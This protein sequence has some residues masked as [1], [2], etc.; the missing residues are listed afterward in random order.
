MLAIATMIERLQLCEWAGLLI[1]NQVVYT[2]KITGVATVYMG[3]V[4]GIC[5][6]LSSIIQMFVTDNHYIQDEGHGCGI[7]FVPFGL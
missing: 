2:T 3:F 1:S 6:L 7:P 5:R 4:H